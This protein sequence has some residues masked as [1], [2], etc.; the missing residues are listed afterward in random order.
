ML[1]LKIENIPEDMKKQKNWVAF[2]IR[3]GK[4][5][6]IDP[7]T[8]ETA[9][10]SDPNT[11]GTFEQAVSMVEGGFYHAIGYAMTEGDKLIF[12]DVDYRPDRCTSK[13]Q[14]EKHKQKYNALI[15]DINKF[16]TY[17]ETS[18]S[19]EGVHLLAKGSLN[20]ELKTGGAEEWPLEIYGNEDKRFIIMTGHKMNDCDIADDE[21]TIGT[22]NIFHK[23]YF[24]KKSSAPAFTPSTTSPTNITAGTP[25]PV[26]PP[27]EKPIRSDEEVIRLILKDK[28]AALLWNDHWDEV[29]DE[30]GNA[31]YDSQHYSD[32]GLI[33][34]I[35][36]Y[37]GNCPTQ[38]DRIFRMSP[39]YQQYGKD[40]KWTK[41]ESD[42]R[43]DIQTVSS[44]CMA[45]YNPNYYKNNTGVAKINPNSLVD[46]GMGIPLVNPLEW[47]PDFNQMENLLH[48]KEECP[49]KNAALIGLLKAYVQKYKYR[50][51]C[52]YPGLFKEDKNI[53]GGTFIVQRILGENFKYSYNFGKYFIWDNKRYKETDDFETLIHPITVALGLVEHSV[54]EWVINYVAPFQNP[55]PAEGEEEPEE[56]TTTGSAK[57]KLTPKDYLELRAVELF[58]YSKGFVSRTLAQDILK[59]Y[60]GMSIGDDILTYYETP[61]MNMQNGMFNM[62]TREFTP[63]HDPGCNLY[64]ITNC[65]FDPNADCP[66]FRAM[67]E[68]L[69]PDPAERKELQ[70]AFGL[71]LAK[72]QVAAKKI[73]VMLIGPKDSGKSFLLNTLVD[74]LGD[75]AISIDNSLLMQTGRDTTKGPE[76]YDFKDN[77]MITASE[78][79][80]TKDK[81]NLTRI[82]GLSGETTQ[83]IR[84]LFS[85]KMDKFKMIGIIY[86]DSNAKPFLDPRDPAAH[87]RLRL[88]QLPNAIKVK[89]PTLKSKLVAERPGIFN[90]LLEGLD[91]VLE[92]KEIFETPEMLTR[93]KEYKDSMDTTEQFLKDCIEKVD[94]TNQ[95][96]PTSMLFTTYKNWAKDNGFKDT[97][98][99]KFYEEI[100]KTFDK[101]KSGVEYFIG[102][103]FT[104]LGTLYSRMN[105]NTIQEFAK[106]KRKIIEGS[107]MDLPYNVLRATHYEKSSEWFF[108]V[109]ET[110]QRENYIQYCC[111][112]ADRALVPLRID[113]FEAKIEFLKKKIDSGYISNQTIIDAK[114]IWGPNAF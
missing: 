54:F 107:K 15:N 4:K 40:D 59:K 95:R 56:T 69:I 5:I 101:K 7:N 50:P 64:K 42:I 106:K 13:E 86:I 21:M 11:W 28:K 36:F 34:K 65:D 62:V 103:R 31:E 104:E 43:K 112:C 26:F 74:T 2:V 29:A 39:C 82:K 92:E 10:I 91:M 38:M 46:M 60:K 89:D 48:N 70:K 41:Y 100:G 58:K 32:C 99:N 47:K 18:L 33:R 79:D 87:D 25:D 85:K 78:T 1:K 9:S 19:G 114:E 20:P 3:N 90:W 98:R 97:V 35:C 113:D 84:N 63:F 16:S 94:D 71:C 105:E 23:H 37:S 109:K 76:M 67:M 72:E 77:L 8:N 102:L 68:R 22:I 110:T 52:Y 44:T 83:S 14:L 73:F 12:I 108:N 81:L 53:N 96:I 93:K 57:P 55:E 66:E 51:V 27:I 30:N 17:M 45:V 80:D 75:Y 111:W 49:F 24:P 88:F 61:Y 6:P